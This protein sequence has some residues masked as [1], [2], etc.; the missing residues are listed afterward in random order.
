MVA[1]AMAAACAVAGAQ[2]AAAASFK[3]DST[4][5]LVD[6][7][8]GDGTCAAAGGECTLRA[9]MK[10][11]NLGVRQLITITVP[12]GRYKM[13]RPPVAGVGD[14]GQNGA[15]YNLAADVTVQGAGTRETV[16]DANRLDRAFFNHGPTAR[17]TINDLSIVNGLS[18]A[19]IPQPGPVGGGAIGSTG[20]VTLNRVTLSHNEA[21]VG[22]ALM[23]GQIGTTSGPAQVATVSFLE[24][25][26][27]TVSDNIAEMEGGGMRI[28][29]GARIVN[30]TIT[31]NKVLSDCCAVEPLNQ[32]AQ[33]EGGG[34]D[35]PAEAQ[36][37]IINSTITNNHAV[38]GGGGI[39]A[40]TY[41]D[42]VLGHVA[43]GP[44]LL[45]NTII[46][47]NTSEAG[48]A[49][50]KHGNPRIISLGHNILGDDT[51][52]PTADD[53]HRNTAGLGAFGNH[54]GPTDTVELLPGSPAIDAAFARSCQSLDQRGTTRSGT[55]DIGAFEYVPVK[56]RSAPAT[57]PTR[58][59][60]FV[61]IRGLRGRRIRSV[62]VRINGKRRAVS[63]KGALV[64]IT[65]AGLNVRV[66][67]VTIV[68]R[69][70]DGRR[71][72]DRRSYRL[73]TK[74]Q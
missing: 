4:A 25:N 11:A 9:A 74:R 27:S 53:L 44:V 69:T 48:P 54:G 30:T 23:T 57:C 36:V 24:M 20:W 71:V 73:C 7:S 61:T 17:L 46:V 35:M 32:V 58:R 29:S 14:L 10:E 68:A 5:D 3:V 42:D 56:A 63:R 47:G 33:G 28:D 19:T 50:C 67:R 45:Q 49:N 18:S 55:C 70:T 31:G 12:A 59:T 65:F 37:Q 15:F 43:N 39:N 62:D 52:N 21:G 66:V 2:E 41:A 51:C 16:I 40:T 6:A 13:T 64:R 22:G 60:M 26:D 1:V 8:P 72:I 34:I 38:I